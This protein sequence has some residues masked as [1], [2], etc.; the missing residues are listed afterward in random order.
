MNRSFTCAGNYARVYLLRAAREDSH[1]RTMYEL[2]LY[3][4]TT[5][6]QS[7]E[8]T[9]FE[10]YLSYENE[11]SCCSELVHPSLASN[12]GSSIRCPWNGLSNHLDT[13]I[14]SALSKLKIWFIPPT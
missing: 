8:C 12:D 14:S 2:Q 3:G 6:R 11:K 4:H 5:S 9:V 7:Q 10:I 13:A 1:A